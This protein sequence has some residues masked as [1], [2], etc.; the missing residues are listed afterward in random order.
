MGGEC[1]VRRRE[2]TGTLVSLRVPLRFPA[3]RRTDTDKDI[4][5]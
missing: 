3:E 5:P 1:V 2:P 4:G